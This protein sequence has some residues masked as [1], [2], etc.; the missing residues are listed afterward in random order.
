MKV[1]NI[2][3]TYNERKTIGPMLEALIKIAKENPQYEFAHLIA[4]DSSPDGTADIVKKYIEKHKNIHLITGPKKGL[5]EALLR[6]YQY[7]VEKMGAEVIIPNDADQS[8][9]PEYIPQLLKKIDEGYDVVVGSRH[10]SKGGTE[11]W[12]LFRKLNHWVANILFATYVAG[13]KEVKDHN[14]NFKAI[15]VRGVLDQV[16][17]DK[18]L[19]KIKIRGFVIQTYILYELSKFTKKF[20]EVPVIFKFN[21]EAESKVS[22]KKYFKTYL[23]DVLEYIKICIL[24][25]LEK[26]KQFLRFATVGFIGYLV[27]AFGLELFYRFGLQPGP[28]AALGAEL[29]IISNFTLNNLWTF[30]EKKISGWKNVSWKFFHFNLTSLGAVVIQGIVVGLLARFFGDQWRQIYL[31]I[32]IGFF[33]IPYNYTM[34]NL[35]IWRTW[36]LPWKKS[37]K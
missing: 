27:N 32:A 12:N 31:I 14:G 17:L 26:S 28:A 15:R 5:G 2:I 4:D 36:K 23:R 37:K 16:P 25:R 3:P 34:Y 1:V 13:I 7:A 9:S 30:A 22:S 35:F 18:F 21:P 6:S 24:I 10:V 11:G 20:I 29:A 19:E 8:F 33:V